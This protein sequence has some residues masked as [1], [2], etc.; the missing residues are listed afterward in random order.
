MNTRRWI[1]TGGP[2]LGLLFVSVIF[3]ALIGPRFFA[4]ANLELIA[5]QTAIVCTVALGMTMIIVS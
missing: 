1:E 4:G 5:R 3:G 2:L